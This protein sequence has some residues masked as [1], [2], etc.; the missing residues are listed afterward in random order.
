MTTEL[1]LAWAAGLFDGEGHIGAHLCSGTVYT[2]WKLSVL[3]SNVHKPTMD[4]FQSLVGGRMRLRKNG[5]GNRKIWVLRLG[6]GVAAAAL[7]K[8]LPY[9]VTKKEQAE[10][11]LE[12]RK[13]YGGN[14]RGAGVL[15]PQSIL[16]A[17]S[18]I[19]AQIKALNH[20]R[21]AQ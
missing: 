9:L 7:E 11:A 21:E 19:A 5:P 16:E 6:E 1:D 17:R 2:H 4:K 10:L 12:F 20:G 18:G 14:V 3:V 8:L 13:T 15:L